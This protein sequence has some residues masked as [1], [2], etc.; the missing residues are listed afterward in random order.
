MRFIP[1][2]PISFDLL[3]KQIFGHMN[4]IGTKLPIGNTEA[5]NHMVYNFDTSGSVQ[6]CQQF[7]PTNHVVFEFLVEFLVFV[8]MLPEVHLKM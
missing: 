2:I 3:N 7:A 5:R 1:R 8:Y 4:E 6:H